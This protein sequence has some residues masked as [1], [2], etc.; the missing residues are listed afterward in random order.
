MVFYALCFSC[1][2]SIISFFQGSFLYP[3][4]IRYFFLWYV[5]FSLVFM[6]L[7]VHWPV[8][9]SFRI[10]LTL[11]NTAIFVFKH[12]IL[13]IQVS[14]L[15]SI[16]IIWRIRRHFFVRLFT[17][18]DSFR[19]CSAQSILELPVN[20][21][22]SGISSFKGRFRFYS[23]LSILELCVDISTSGISSGKG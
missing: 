23:V 17:C 22:S 10:I 13:Q 5:S 16:F 2:S 14:F 11:L 18:K 6:A 21:F 15:F 7:F 20:I 8:F 12:F 19:I 1:A 9:L 3:G 4:I